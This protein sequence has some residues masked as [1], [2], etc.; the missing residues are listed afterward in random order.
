MGR[1][2]TTSTPQSATRWTIEDA[3]SDRAAIVQYTS[4]GDIP[5][6]VTI[7]RYIDR[8]DPCDIGWAFVAEYPADDCG[9]RTDSGP[10]NARWWT[11]APSHVQDAASM[12][13]GE[14]EDA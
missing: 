2:N 6:A 1:M 11:D 5:E 7:T 10:A 12:M 8:S 13:Q 3:D 9:E 14:A 4:V